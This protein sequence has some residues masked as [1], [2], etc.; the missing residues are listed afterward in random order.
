M[1]FLQTHTDKLSPVS[2]CT[3]TGSAVVK[4]QTVLRFI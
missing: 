3:Y 1:I 4:K 2:E